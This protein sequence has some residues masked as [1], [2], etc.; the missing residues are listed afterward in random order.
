M[1]VSHVLLS[2]LFDNYAI[3]ID[4]AVYVVFSHF[5]TFC[6]A[7]QIP[8]LE[9]HFILH[10]LKLDRSYLS[11][12]HRIVTLL[13]PPR[14]TSWKVGSKPRRVIW[15]HVT[16]CCMLCSS[17]FMSFLE[18]GFLCVFLNSPIIFSSFLGFWACCVLFSKICFLTLSLFILK[19][20]WFFRPRWKNQRRWWWTW[21]NRGVSTVGNVGFRWLCYLETRW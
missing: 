4:H 14:I 7:L 2:T 15:F 20:E 3:C 16:V 5:H 9:A 18:I 11:S 19:P 12:K 10:I 6:R 17:S 1:Q 21:I 13:H 8:T